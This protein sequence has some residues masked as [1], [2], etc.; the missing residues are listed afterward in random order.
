[1]ARKDDNLDLDEIMNELKARSDGTWVEPK[2]KPRPEPVRT[3]PAKAEKAK[4]VKTKKKRGLLSRLLIN[5]FTVGLTAISAVVGYGYGV[6][7][8]V[9]NNSEEISMETLK[10][11]ATDPGNAYAEAYKDIAVPAYDNLIAPSFDWLY[12]TTVSAFNDSA[13]NTNNAEN[14][15]EAPAPTAAPAPAPEPETAPA[16]APRAPTLPALTPP[17]A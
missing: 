9:I 3:Q 14:N 5:K 10:E 12:E 6:G 17:G 8:N 4:P 16:P 15:A 2:V 11:A 1:M 13:D 7:D